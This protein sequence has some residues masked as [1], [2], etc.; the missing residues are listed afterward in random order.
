MSLHVQVNFKSCMLG[1]TVDL[2]PHRN[3][4]E[5]KTVRHA[6]MRLHERMMIERKYT[7]SILN[8][9]IAML[10]AITFN[11]AQNVLI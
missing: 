6:C 1:L 11:K 8:F 4:I 7:F 10:I 9:Y 2:L 5:E 3:C